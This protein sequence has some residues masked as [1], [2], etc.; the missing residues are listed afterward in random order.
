MGKNNKTFT[1]KEVESLIK[2]TYEV[3]FCDGIDSNGDYNEVDANKFWGQNIDEWLL[4]KIPYIE[5]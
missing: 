1:L 2:Y 5:L 3:G 4:G